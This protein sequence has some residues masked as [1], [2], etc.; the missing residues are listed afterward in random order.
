MTTIDPAEARPRLI[1][2]LA[3][4]LEALYDPAVV[5]VLAT[6]KP[7][8]MRSGGARVPGTSYELPASTAARAMRALLALR[9]GRADALLAKLAE[10][11]EAARF[12]VLTGKAPPVIASL[13]PCC[14]PDIA[15][16]GS[17]SLP[18]ALRR[19]YLAAERI[20]TLTH[21]R[22]IDRQC[23]DW[24]ERPESLDQMPVQQFVAGFVRNAPP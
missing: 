14:T 18:D 9:E 11:D 24:S 13:Y 16:A 17:A 8:D 2:T 20:F 4:L 12:A 3:G 15:S 22:R 19:L 6:L 5:S 10:A 7:A 21:M 1:A 23:F